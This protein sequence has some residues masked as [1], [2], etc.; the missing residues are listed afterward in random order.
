MGSL[1]KPPSLVLIYGVLC[2]VERIAFFLAV[3]VVCQLITRINLLSSATR[4]GII[5]PLFLCSLWERFHPQL[6]D[7]VI[8]GIAGERSGTC[9]FVSSSSRLVVFPFPSIVK[10]ISDFV[11]EEIAVDDRVVVFAFG[12]GIGIAVG[13]GLFV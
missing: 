4:T 7:N 5:I 8:S 13:G 12:I 1:V 11:H 3:V 6:Y 9:N 2:I 10:V